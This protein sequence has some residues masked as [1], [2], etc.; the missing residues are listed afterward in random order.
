MQELRQWQKELR[1]HHNI[2]KTVAQFWAQQQ[3]RGEST[4]THTHSHGI[5][6]CQA[7]GSLAT[8]YYSIDLEFSSA[9]QQ[10][11]LIGQQAL[12]FTHTE[13]RMYR[14]QPIQIHT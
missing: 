2:A 6:E 12:T 5:S 3:S 10:L 13:D 9:G 11:L 4:K 14:Y 7:S 8:Q 1:Q